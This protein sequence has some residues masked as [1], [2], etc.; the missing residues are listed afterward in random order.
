MNENIT[1]LD[2]KSERKYKKTRRKKRRKE[3]DEDKDKMS[4]KRYILENGKIKPGIN[5]ISKEFIDSLQI[6]EKNNT[7]YYIDKNKIEQIY[8]PMNCFITTHEI[9]KIGYVKIEFQKEENILSELR[10][11]LEYGIHGISKIL[12]DFLKPSYS[13]MII[14]NMSLQNLYVQIEEDRVKTVAEEYKSFFCGI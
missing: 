11:D 3:R 14:E 5:V 7:I 6:T 10:I 9:W 2:K 4:I 12:P 1:T 13:N 8:H